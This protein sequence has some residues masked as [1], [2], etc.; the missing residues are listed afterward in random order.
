MSKIF[1]PLFIAL[2]LSACGLHGESGSSSNDGEAKTTAAKNTKTPGIGLSSEPSIGKP[3]LLASLKDGGYV[4][5][6]R[7]ATTERDYAD[8]A[9]PLMSLDDC[10]SQRKLSTKGIK[11][12]HGIGMAFAAKGIPVGEIIVSEYCR[13]WK[14]AN[15]AFGEWTRKDS[16]LN[17]LPYEDY[18]K[19]HV[20][21]MKKNVM[22]LL[23]RQPLP[24]TNTV[25]IGHDDP[26]EAVTGIYPEPQGI[27]YILQP[28]GRRSFKIIDS[29]LPSEWAT[30]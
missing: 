16:R 1:I 8:Q 2:L 10:S 14:T 23:T 4:I 27:A 30:L 7:H 20:E 26:F 29:V 24:G 3:M 13:S 28:D 12:S 6:F 18:T 22:P 5:Y 19:S 25:I 11:E 17:F 9:D 15:L 21:L